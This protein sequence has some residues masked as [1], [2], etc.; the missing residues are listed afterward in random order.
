MCSCALQ[1]SA[2]SCNVCCIPYHFQLANLLLGQA[3]SEFLFYLRKTLTLNLCRKQEDQC[4]APA[5]RVLC[6]NKTSVFCKQQH[7]SFARTRRCVTCTNNKPV[8]RKSNPALGQ[9]QK[10]PSFNSNLSPAT[11]GRQTPEIDV[12]YSSVSCV[13]YHLKHGLTVDHK[14][15]FTVQGSFF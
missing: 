11:P 8:L 15:H 4:L 7:Q 12:I 1:C 14:L 10:L 2:V 13:Q 9:Q 5:P 6:A 3:P